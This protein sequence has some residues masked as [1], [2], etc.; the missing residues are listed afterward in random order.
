MH[1]NA[2]LL[3]P[4]LNVPLPTLLGLS[5]I[6]ITKPWEIAGHHIGTNI[7]KVFCTVFMLAYS[8]LFHFSYNRFH[9]NY[10]MA[11]RQPCLLLRLKLSSSR[12]CD[13]ESCF[14]HGSRTT[15]GQLAGETSLPLVE[16][17]PCGNT[18]RN[19]C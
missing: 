17:F 18:P 19:R 4:K 9:G 6:C 8:V 10:A 1:L 3:A 14:L 15:T 5:H 12:V 11:K 13:F 7:F 16:N 2:H